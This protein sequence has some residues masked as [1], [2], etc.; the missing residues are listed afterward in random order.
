MERRYGYNGAILHIDLTEQRSWVETP[1]EDWFRIYGGGGLMG[2]FFMM[3]DIE[4]GID[5]FD[6]KNLLIFASSV[7]AGND[8]P[9]M[10]RFSVVSKSPLSGGIAETRVEGPFGRFLKGSSYDAV[11]CHGTAA[12][13]VVVVLEGGQI[14]F[15][16]ADDLWGQ[17]TART[18]ATLE[19]RYADSSKGLVRDSVQIATIGPAGENKVRYASIVTSYCIQA[20]R[21]GVG[22]V[23]GSKNLKAFVLCGCQTTPVADPEALASIKSGFAER[24]LDNTLSRWQKNPPGFSASADLSDYDTA[25][26]GYENYRSNL[27]V[28][29]S[30]YT[31]SKYLEFNSGHIACPGCPNDCIKIIDPGASNQLSAGIHQEVTGSMGPNLG[32]PNLKLMLEANVLCNESGLDPVSPGFSL[33]FAMEC[34]DAGAIGPRRTD[35][36]DLSFGNESVIIPLIKDIAYRRGFGD[37]LAEGTRRAAKTIVISGWDHP[38]EHSRTLRILKRLPMQHVGRDKVR[39]YKVLN[40]IRSACDTLNLCIFASAPTRVLSLEMIASLVTAV[41]GWNTSSYEFMRW[42]ERRNHLMRAYNLREGLVKDQDT[43]P[44]RFFSWLWMLKVELM[45]SGCICMEPWRSRGLV[46]AKHLWLLIFD[47]W[48]ERSVRLRWPWIIMP[49]MMSSWWKEPISSTVTTLPRTL[50][51]RSPS[52][53]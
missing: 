46:V 35:G 51:K 42:G 5:A 26:I 21:V 17:N 45:V 32:N 52:V 34:F 4:A 7:I 20:M 47:G 12:K 14:R 25:Y 6:P 24:M 53:E 49:T 9:G 18:T 10:A 13:P 44:Q 33:S 19:S 11:I 23:M 48:L 27:K 1:D 38:L 3:R 36:R 37:I 39:N 31:R 29:N 22:A 15:Y 2:A 41:T 40:T 8:G 50:M 28:E 16:P 43:L 30:D